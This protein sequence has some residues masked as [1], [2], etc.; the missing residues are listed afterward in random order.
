MQRE[1]PQREH[2]LAVVRHLRWYG[3]W[4]LYCKEPLRFCPFLLFEFSENPRAT[5]GPPTVHVRATL[6]GHGG[7]S[8][9]WWGLEREGG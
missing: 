6:L 2:N 7:R 4:S 1:A 3:S 8:G 9:S 5:A